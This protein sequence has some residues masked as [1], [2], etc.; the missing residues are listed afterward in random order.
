MLLA[1]GSDLPLGAHLAS[2]S[3]YRTL[4]DV[5]YGGSFEG[6]TAFGVGVRAR[7]PFRVFT[8]AGPGNHSR[9]VIDVAH[10]W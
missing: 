8:L 10:H 4:R 9:I 6:Y 1:N 3:G 2:V 5:V 7:P